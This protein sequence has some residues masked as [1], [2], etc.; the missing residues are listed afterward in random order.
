MRKA[1]RQRQAHLEAGLR[2]FK[3]KDV[4]D[5]CSR[6]VKAKAREALNEQ[7][8]GLEK[9]TIDLLERQNTLVAID[10]YHLLENFQALEALAAR[11]FED[12]RFEQ[13]LLSFKKAPVSITSTHA[14]F[15]LKFLDAGRFGEALGMTKHMYSA[16]GVDR[17]IIDQSKKFLEL[18][19]KVKGC[20]LRRFEE[21]PPQMEALQPNVQQLLDIADHCEDTQTLMD[22]YGEAESA[23]RNEWKYAAGVRLLNVSM[24]TSTQPPKHIVE[25]VAQRAYQK[26]DDINF[27]RT[28]YWRFEDSISIHPG[29]IDERDENNLLEISRQ[30]I[31]HGR[32]REAETVLL[33]LLRSQE[34]SGKTIHMISRLLAECRAADPKKDR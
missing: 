29:I 19:Q 33:S 4:V 1:E 18:L 20:L 28:V 2:S 22:F 25:Y 16:E 7:L 9:S 14:E 23:G 21:E 31:I 17:A 24:K 8:T 6:L 13:S 12:A 27:N 15:A 32:L 34:V 3:R 11:L 30:A 26:G 10:V 5:G